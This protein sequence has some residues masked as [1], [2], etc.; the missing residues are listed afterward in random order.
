MPVVIKELVINAIVDTNAR[1]SES[2]PA[3]AASP[4]A[5]MQ[6]QLVKQCVRQVLDILREK[7]ER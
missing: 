7:D 2:T 1:P 5:E 6:K 4:S 3:A